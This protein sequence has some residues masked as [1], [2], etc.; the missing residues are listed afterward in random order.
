M[1]KKSVKKQLA[2]WTCP[3]WEIASCP[4]VCQDGGNFYSG[5]TKIVDPG[6]KPGTYTFATNKCTYDVAPAANTTIACASLTVKCGETDPNCIWLG[7]ECVK[8][9][10]WGVE[11][12]TAIE[13]CTRLKAPLVTADKAN[14]LLGLTSGDVNSANPSPTITNK[15]NTGPCV[16]AGGWTVEGFHA[17]SLTDPGSCTWTNDG[18]EAS[19]KIVLN[20]RD[21]ANFTSGYQN[22]DTLRSWANS[23]GA[24]LVVPST[25][26]NYGQCVAHGKKITGFKQINAANPSKCVWYDDGSAAAKNVKCKDYADFSLPMVDSLTKLASWATTCNVVLADVSA[27]PSPSAPSPSST[28]VSDLTADNNAEINIDTVPE[29]TETQCLEDSS[30]DGCADILIKGAKLSSGKFNC[31]KNKNYPGCSSCLS[32]ESSVDCVCNPENTLNGIFQ[33]ECDA[34]LNARE[35]PPDCS[36]PN[37]DAF[38][39]DK[40]P[41][42]CDDLTSPAFNGEKCCGDSQNPDYVQ[43]CCSDPNA[44][45]YQKDVC[46]PPTTWSENKNLIIGI[47]AFVGAVLFIL[48]LYLVFRKK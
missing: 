21:T 8:N 37:S 47:S 4:K 26:I 14:T 11:T 1:S 46:S 23:C 22:I 31:T 13:A 17:S 35:K 48:I 25:T 43:N 3:T 15:T 19:K 20:C 7:K 18:S 12:G 45:Y 10:K 29:L 40:C 34:E 36:D 42:V 38:D 41:P 27:A 39:F 30:L 44:P 6:V 5:S 33:D 24:S 2:T 32:P 28:P 16:Q 9:S